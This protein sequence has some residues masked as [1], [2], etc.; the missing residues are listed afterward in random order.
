MKKLGRNDPCS[1][2]S[3]KKFKRCCGAFVQSYKLSI[4]NQK[5]LE[6]M[7][8]RHEAM[9]MQRAKQQ[10]LGRQIV[11]AEVKGTRF[12]A[13]NN[14]VMYSKSWKTFSD[15]LTD[16]IKTKIGGD[17]GNNEIHNKP[18][19]ER[20]HLLVWYQKLCLLQQKYSKKEGELFEAPITGAVKAY[21]GLAYDLYCLDHH[22]NLQQVLIARLKN[23]DHNFYGVRYE[24]AIAAKMIRAGFDIEFED[25][26]DRSTTHCEF[27]AKSKLTG[28]CFSVECKQL[29][30]S[31][32][33][34]VVNLKMLVRRFVSALSKQALHTRIVFIDLNFPYDPK[35]H[36]EYPNAM[37]LAQRHLRKLE[38]NVVNG[39]CLPPAYVFLTNYPCHH[40]LDDVNVGFALM[41][42][43]FKIPEFK[44]DIGRTLHDAIDIRDR[45]IDL[46]E[47][48]KSI[49]KHSEVPSTF[50]GEIPEF[51]FN[52]DMQVNRL[53]I[54]ES[55]AV[56]D[57]NGNDCF[58]E[59]ENATVNQNDQ[60]AWGIMRLRDG[61]RIITKFNL[62]EEE[63]K[64][65]QAHPDTFF[66]NVSPVSKNTQSPL[67]MY[68]FFLKGFKDTA[69]GVLLDRFAASP[70][71]EELKQLSQTEL[72]RMYAEHCTSFALEQK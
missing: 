34:N 38:G 22:S 41:A 49:E 11:S 64:A 59:L 56:P 51:A 67:D 12:V 6:Q 19:D 28:K 63:L 2:G 33:D 36:N 17:W 58:G 32:K 42:D 60:T 5:I 54:G 43:G 48:M 55:Y 23:P 30:S 37:E 39:G 21:N 44:A 66:G 20:H 16:Y 40:H 27:T 70:N 18:E 14:N 4:E 15:F 13:V 53:L 71:I 69:K 52:P 7:L 50:D 24:I 61:N 35:I 1:C 25:E 9:S 72:A 57:A 62:S 3:C 29:E 65:Y 26:S 31:G 45:H 46:V 10:G 8:N 68:D 47:L